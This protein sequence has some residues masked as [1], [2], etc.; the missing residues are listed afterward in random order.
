MF[1]GSVHWFSNNPAQSDIVNRSYQNIKKRMKGQNSYYQALPNAVCRGTSL[2]LL[3][4]LWL[5]KTINKKR[6]HLLSQS[7][8]LEISVFLSQ[9][10]FQV[11]RIHTTLKL[12]LTKQNKKSLSA[13]Q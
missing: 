8:T 13:T 1:L 10:E 12:D 11:P 6:A 2:V 5:V 7:L 3:Y 4:T 9:T